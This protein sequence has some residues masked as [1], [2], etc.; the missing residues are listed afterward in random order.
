MEMS[1]PTKGPLHI[2][3]GPGAT[4]MTV[5]AA[6]GSLI[7]T[8]TSGQLPVG[9]CRANARLGWKAPDLLEH[10]RFVV[11]TLSDPKL[12]EGE[13]LSILFATLGAM[14]TTIEHVVLDLPHSAEAESASHKETIDG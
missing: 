2:P 4:R 6:D 10:L 7:G 5:W 12:S 1:L 11:D 8:Y 9:E 3:S 13:M 14:R